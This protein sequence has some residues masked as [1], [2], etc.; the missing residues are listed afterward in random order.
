MLDVL[1]MEMKSQMTSINRTIRLRELED[2]EYSIQQLRDLDRLLGP[3]MDRVLHPQ[4]DITF[5]AK[6][7]CGGA[8]IARRLRWQR[9]RI[10]RLY[11]REL[12]ETVREVYSL[13]LQNIEPESE[14]S[15]FNRLLVDRMKL[16]G[17]LMILRLSAPACLLPV[18]LGARLTGLVGGQLR[19]EFGPPAEVIS[20][21]LVSFV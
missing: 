11:V 4:S 2:G 3:M 6:H 18:P 8:K 9:F 20:E 12:A 17:W 5:A 15:S 1:W 13:S 19:R 16:S 14:H 7:G 21:R 10:F